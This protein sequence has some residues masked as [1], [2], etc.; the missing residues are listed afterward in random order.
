MK[1]SYIRLSGN[2]RAC[3]M[4]SS[5]NQSCEKA[6]RNRFNIIIK[7]AIHGKFKATYQ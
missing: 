2:E 3:E 5:D 7:N 4:K 1:K 6:L